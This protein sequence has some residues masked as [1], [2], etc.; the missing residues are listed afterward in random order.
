MKASD[1]TLLLAAGTGALTGIRSMSAVAVVSLR[2]RG[3][4]EDFRYG[5]ARW[6][7]SEQAPGLL[8]MAAA[9]ELAGD[10]L[11]FVPAR[12]RP[13]PLLGR[14]A[15]GALCGAA[16]AQMRGTSPASAAAT[17]ALA[18]VASATVVTGLRRFVTHRLHVPDFLIG[19]TED[20][21]VLRG[22]SVLHRELDV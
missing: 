21:V 22:A 9:G 1:R 20:Y 15:F 19:L 6:L 10:K 14:A 5:P 2:L 16:I 3:Q 17:G 18:A 7:A 11:P 13:A 8:S 12:T 4:K